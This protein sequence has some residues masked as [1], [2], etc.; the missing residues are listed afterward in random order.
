ML[1]R[2]QSFPVASFPFLPPAPLVMYGRRM[3]CR[4]DVLC[5]SPQ[6]TW[7]SVAVTDN[8]PFSMVSHTH[9]HS[10]ELSGRNVGSPGWTPTNHQ[11]SSAQKRGARAGVRDG[12]WAAD[13]GYA[14]RSRSLP[15][16]VETRRCRGF[17]NPTE[18]RKRSSKTWLDKPLCP[19]H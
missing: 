5:R 16:L 8:A 2:V 4:R 15:A 6:C 1:V 3:G 14:A 12:G 13:P 18:P 10:A 11:P 9:P 17:K 7:P 19:K